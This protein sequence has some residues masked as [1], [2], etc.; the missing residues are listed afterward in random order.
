MSTERR[1]RDRSY[2]PNRSRHVPRGRERLLLMPKTFLSFPGIEIMTKQFAIVAL[3]AAFLL[4]GCGS[5]QLKSPDWNL[6]WSSDEPETPDRVLAFWN[7]SMMHS[8]SKDKAQRGFTGRIMFH[9]EGTEEPIEV[10]G[11]LI[12]YAYEEE[13]RDP[14]NPIP[15]RRLVIT[16]EQLRSSEFHR[17]TEMGHAYDIW[18]E[19]G[20]A[21]AP[22]K[23]VSLI[24]RFT[25]VNGEF[26]VS[27]MAEQVLPGLGE[28]EPQVTITEHIEPLHDIASADEE[29][30]PVQRASYETT[31]DIPDVGVVSE[32]E[33]DASAEGDIRLRSTTISIPQGL[34]TSTPNINERIYP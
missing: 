29:Q 24:A 32:G 5:L 3:L 17:E 10:D 18:F 6:P 22:R 34:G 11:T 23:D 15:D 25:P 16:P 13:G 31:T 20:D 7:T 4:T 33:N 8:A 26:I 9:K 14:S 27:G 2:S 28:Y 1:I 21:D 30:A 19:W 12:V